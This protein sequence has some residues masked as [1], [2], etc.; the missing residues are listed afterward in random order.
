MAAIIALIAFSDL[1]LFLISFKLLASQTLKLGVLHFAE[2]R[3]HNE[4]H[5]LISLQAITVLQG[6]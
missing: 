6:E 2:L 1:L 5:T 4:L 3:S